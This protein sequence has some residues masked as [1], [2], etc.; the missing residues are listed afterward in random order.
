MSGG[1][2][3]VHLLFHSIGG[4]PSDGILLYN[5]FTALPIELTLY[6]AG[7]VESA[8]TV[9]YL[10]AKN[11]KV[12]ANA[13]FMI[14]KTAVSP[15]FATASKLKAATQSLVLDDERTEAILREHLKLS[16]DHWKHH[17]H[18]N[19]WFSADEA[20]AVGLAH[21]VASFFPPKGT[22]IFNI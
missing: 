7:S 4:F 14:H 19:V 8:A 12:S 1:V 15:Q 2:K 5:Y 3:H 17:E 16:D 18:H 13:A 21:G 20:V 9:A 10:G 22:R 11:R 6:N